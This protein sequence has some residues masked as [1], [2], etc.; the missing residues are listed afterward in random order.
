MS[1]VDICALNEIPQ[2]GAHVVMAPHGDIA[3]FRTSADKVFALDDRCPQT[4][5]PLSQGVVFGNTVA[6]PQHSWQIQLDSNEVIV[7]D[8]ACSQRYPTRIEAG[9]V[10][11]AVEQTKDTAR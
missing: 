8:V 11:I 7:I 2:P 1:W 10:Q 3:I 4:G 5:A 6:C 9:R